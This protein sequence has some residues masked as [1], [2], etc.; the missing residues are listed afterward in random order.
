MNDNH[1]SPA[2]KENARVRAAFVQCD[3]CVFVFRFEVPVHADWRTVIWAICAI[4]ATYPDSVERKNWWTIW[5]TFIY[6]ER[7]L[8]E[9]VKV[10]VRLS[11][12]FMQAVSSVWNKPDRRFYL[13]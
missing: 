6:G 7:G 5:Y 2:P 13:K 1:T 11:N 9:P 12:S 4:P 3:S 8:Q 10:R